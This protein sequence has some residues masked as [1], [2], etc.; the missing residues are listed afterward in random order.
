MAVLAA[1]ALVLPEAA[2]GGPW[3]SPPQGGM[4]A[5]LDAE[6]V[7]KA[8]SLRRAIE[9]RTLS[10]ADK[11]EIRACDRD[12]AEFLR[13][14]RAGEAGYAEVD[15]RIREAKIG[16]ADPNDPA[17]MALLER[18]FAFEK[19]FDERYRATPKGKSCTAG[20]A[21]RQKAIAAALEKDREYQALLKRIA[22]S[23]RDHM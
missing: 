2:P 16:G 23:S 9:R 5:P 14:A 12:K 17:V 22:S 10:D 21:R 20:E 11:K 15:A 1:L 13:K 4:G 8:D 19:K 18:K 3:A 7:A 6:L